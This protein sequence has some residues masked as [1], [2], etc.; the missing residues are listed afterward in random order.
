[1]VLACGRFA[2]C[3]IHPW[4]PRSSHRPPKHVRTPL[5]AIGDLILA[6]Q[7]FVHLEDQD[8][9]RAHLRTGSI[10]LSATIPT[11]LRLEQVRLTM[12]VEAIGPCVVLMDVGGTI[13]RVE[14]ESG[15]TSLV[16]EDVLMNGT[17]IPI[18]IELVEH[19][20][21][22]INP[23]GFTGRTDRILDEGGSGSTGWSFAGNLSPEPRF[24]AK[25]KT[26]VPHDLMCGT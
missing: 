1:M 13:K 21:T 9:H 3:R 18:H 8:D 10:D 19:Q 15:W 26:E 23:L 24:L 4:S 20:G 7:R 22:W 2:M 17:E 6:R 5:D 25:L 12:M 14:L 16:T 11:S